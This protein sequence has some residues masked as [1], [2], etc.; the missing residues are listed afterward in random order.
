MHES[1]G[2]ISVTSGISVLIDL[3]LQLQSTS[4]TS[5]F[6]TLTIITVRLKC[7]TTIP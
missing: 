3:L 7:L 5:V 2:Y 1:P 6:A 4:M